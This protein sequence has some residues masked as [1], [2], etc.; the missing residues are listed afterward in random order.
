MH[1]ENLEVLKEKAHKRK[2]PEASGSCIV[3]KKF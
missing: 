1:Y 2:K 3:K